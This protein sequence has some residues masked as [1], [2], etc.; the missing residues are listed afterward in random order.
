MLEAVIKLIIEY[1][2]ETIMV[3]KST[4]PVGYTASVREKFH[5][6]KIIFSPEFLRESKV[7]YDNGYPKKIV[8]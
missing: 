8:S 4:N 6:N 7:L 1:N 5:C 3:I 2:P